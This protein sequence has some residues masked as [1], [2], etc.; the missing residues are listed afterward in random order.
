MKSLLQKTLIALTA[1]FVFESS[2]IAQSIKRDEIDR[3]T[4]QRVIETY[5]ETWF[6]LKFGISKFGLSFKLSC[7]DGEYTMPATITTKELVKFTSGDG[8]VLLLDNDETV[9]LT[10]AYLG[11]GEME[12]HR[13]YDFS[14]CFILSNDDIE[15]L[16]N[17]KVT[18]VRVM[19]L[20]GHIDQDIKSHNQS[21]LMDMIKLVER[22]KET[23]TPKKKNKHQNDDT[24]W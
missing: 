3:F 16:K 1:F 7:T 23:D 4:K 14:T 12:I 13:W 21:L 8:I 11:I 24:Y 5:P 20:G 19:Y 2:I 6:S 22:Q 10:T 9:T 18:A 17:N 15:I